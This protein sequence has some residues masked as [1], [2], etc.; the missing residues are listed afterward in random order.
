MPEKPTMQILAYKIQEL[1]VMV[2]EGFCGVHKRQDVSNHGIIKNKDWIIKHEEAEKD[3]REK[4][5]LLIADRENKYRRYTD[6]LWKLGTVILI[7]VYG[8]DKLF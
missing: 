5:T 3:L 8:V 1:T 2:K 4:V 6:L 7:A